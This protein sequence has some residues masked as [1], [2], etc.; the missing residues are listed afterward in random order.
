[1]ARKHKNARPRIRPKPINKSIKPRIKVYLYP[2]KKPGD[3]YPGR[4][5]A[6]GEYEK[7]W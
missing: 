3:I 7:G 1:M 2:Q 6:V 4:V 5:V